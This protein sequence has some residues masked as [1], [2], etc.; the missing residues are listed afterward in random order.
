MPQF[1]Q[2]FTGP[3]RTEFDHLSRGTRTRRLRGHALV[4]F[5]AVRELDPRRTG[6]RD[7]LGAAPLGSVDWMDRA[8][9]RDAYRR[10]Y[11]ELGVV[12][13]PAVGGLERLDAHIYRPLRDAA[14]LT[15]RGFDEEVAERAAAGLPARR[16]FEETALDWTEG[17]AMLLDDLGDGESRPDEL[18]LDADRGTGAALARRR[19]FPYQLELI[20]RRREHAANGRARLGGDPALARARQERME[21]RRAMFGRCDADF[22][23]DGH[24]ELPKVVFVTTLMIADDVRERA[25]RLAG[26]AF[27]ALYQAL[28]SQFRTVT[29]SLIVDG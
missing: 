8:T 11:R 19:S 29:A 21:A 12:L 17:F 26:T 20:W 9:A 27:E 7:P 24:A 14:Y 23:G 1:R 6:G 2:K 4:R 10:A 13:S 16:A 25:S 22:A 15:A 5:L 28:I 18:F 3:G